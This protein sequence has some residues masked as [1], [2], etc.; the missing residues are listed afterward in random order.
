MGDSVEDNLKCEGLLKKFQRGKTLLVSVIETIL[1]IFWQK[2]VATF[3]LS[4]K[5]L[6]ET[7][8]NCF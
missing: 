4:P 5:N 3:G 8:L 7:K 2:N 1:V 6:F